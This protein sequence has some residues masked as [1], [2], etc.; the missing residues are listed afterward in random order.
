MELEYK[1]KWSSSSVEA[2]YKLSLSTGSQEHSKWS[3]DVRQTICSNNSA[4]SKASELDSVKVIVGS[5]R[6]KTMLQMTDRRDVSTAQ[7]VNNFI[8]DKEHQIERSF[9][10]WDYAQNQQDSPAD[11]LHCFN[12]NKHNGYDRKEKRK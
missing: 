10:L 9:A 4:K 7:T 8:W 2:I 1:L 5:S 11:F 6:K 3:M 12:Q